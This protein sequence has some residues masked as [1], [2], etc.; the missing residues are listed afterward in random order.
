MSSRF[1]FDKYRKYPQ[2]FNTSSSFNLFSAKK[3][4]F[5]LLLHKGLKDED[6]FGLWICSWIYEHEEEIALSGC[7][8]ICSS[9]Y[10]TSALLMKKSLDTLDICEFINIFQSVKLNL[11]T[12][13][14]TIVIKELTQNSCLILVSLIVANGR[15]V[16]HYMVLVVEQQSK[17]HNS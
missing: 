4:S 3:S 5:N 8:E 17:L 16:D 1:V 13:T 10:G 11:C 15:L 7:R 14:Q 6:V 2:C 12:P 9:K